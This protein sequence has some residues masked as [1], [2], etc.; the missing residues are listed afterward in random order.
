[1]NNKNFV[2]VLLLFLTFN[3]YSQDNLYSSLTI[4][5]EL[6]KNAN[7]VVRNETIGIEVKAYN[8]MVYTNKRIITILN[9]A[10]NK[11][12]G[13]IMGY[14]NKINIKK[15]E[16][17]IYNEFGKEIKKIKKN[18]FV[19]VSAVD[20]GTLYSD[21]R[22]K[23]LDYTPINYPYTIVF[24]TEVEYNSTAFIPSWRPIEGFYVSTQNAE[25]KI[26]NTSN[27]EIKV[28]ATNFNSFN[29]EKHSNYHYTAKGL[30]AIKPESYSPSFREYTP[31]LR[32]ALTTFDMEG[33]KGVNNDWDD[34][35][36]WVYNDL[37]KN[38]QVL[39]QK[40]KDEIKTLT[41]NAETDID[42]AK[43]I[44]EYMQNKTRYISVQVGIGGWKPM[45]ASDVDRLGYGDC[46]GLSNYTK[47]LLDEVGVESHYAIIYGG[48]GIRDFDKDFSVVQGNHAILG[49]PNNNDYIWLEC[50]SQ[51]VPFGYNANFTD[52]RDALV[53]TPDGGK[54]VHTKIYKTSDNLQAS[55]AV[56]NLDSKGN[57]L[58]QITIE[59]SG[60]QYS[61]HEGLQN[62]ILKDQEL[63]YKA[64]YWDD[65]NKL[66]IVSMAFDN[67]KDSIVFTENVDVSVNKYALVTGGRMLFE[68]NM[69]NKI[70]DAPPRYRNRKLPFEIERG[71]TDIDEYKIILSNKLEVEAIQDDVL[72]E[73]Q[74]G[75]YSNTIKKT[76]DS[77]LLFKRTFILNKGTFNKEDYKAF[78]AFWLKVVKH[79]KSKAVIKLNI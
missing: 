10:G 11:K 73:N 19:D 47:A 69:F 38:T 8:K 2:S 30:K 28:K 1:M 51:T 4:D 9:K 41:T 75:I 64:D 34:F 79:D 12:H 77:T 36:K 76:S 32:A 46:K 49:I 26:I 35:G 53:I 60:T 50:T 55:K 39:P 17:V 13:A 37:T 57:V 40:V 68:P 33:I 56:I 52:D 59:S 78:R 16:A 44:Y 65:I 74:F 63:H 7:A 22:I 66:E 42:K 62:E 21:S 25:Y 27:V 29:I 54:I 43:I 72:I 31:Y 5:P 20:G 45:L 70:S 3:L 6:T 24:E 48:K 67:N 58:A 61:Y 14:D 71:F 23:Y 18:D 15:I